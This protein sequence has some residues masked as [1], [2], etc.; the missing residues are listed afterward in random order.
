MLSCRTFNLPDRPTKRG[1]KSQQ[2]WSLSGC[3]R[4]DRTPVRK[5]TFVN[6][7]LG[8]PAQIVKTGRRIIV[9]LLA[10]NP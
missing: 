10:W 1:R 2:F 3:L 8:V 6:H 7:F 9:R 4:E 5:G